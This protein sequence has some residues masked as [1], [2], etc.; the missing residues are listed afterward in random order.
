VVFPVT[1]RLKCLKF[2]ALLAL[3]RK[4][5]DVQLKVKLNLRKITIMAL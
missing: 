2:M 3:K 1:L 5:L 4:I